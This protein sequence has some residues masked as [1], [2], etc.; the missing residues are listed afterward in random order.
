PY[1]VEGPDG[2]LYAD[3][4]SLRHSYLTLLGRGGVGLIHEPT[5]AVSFAGLPPGSPLDDA[6]DLVPHGL[7][8][9]KAGPQRRLQVGQRVEQ[10]VVRRPPPPLLPEPLDRVQLRAV[11][12]QPLELQVRLPAQ[13]VV[14]R[15]AAVPRRVVDQQHHPRVP[16]ARVNPADVAQVGRERL[17]P[18]AGLAPPA[19]SLPGTPGALQGRAV[20]SGAD[21]V[22]DPEHVE[23]VLAVARAD[24]RPVALDAQGRRQGR[25]HGEAGLVLAQEDEFTG[26]RPFPRSAKSSRA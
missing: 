3:F 2:P 17:L 12:G 7:E 19:G 23:Q 9:A 18:A 6:L 21:Q 16:L 13:G 20:Y 25:H 4:H 1:A 5:A 26:R 22:D 8:V 24:G 11:T 15:P 10:P 14:D